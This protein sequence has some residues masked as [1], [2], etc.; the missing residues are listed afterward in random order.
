MAAID[1]ERF[2]WLRVE[3]VILDSLVLSQRSELLLRER[4]IDLHRKIDERRSANN[5]ELIGIADQLRMS[6]KKK[7]TESTLLKIGVV[8]SFVAGVFVAR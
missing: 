5:L 6:A 1:L 8:V 3:V 2:D 4:E 7:R